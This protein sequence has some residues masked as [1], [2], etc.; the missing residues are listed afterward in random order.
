MKSFFAKN[1][2]WIVIITLILVGIIAFRTRPAR[3]ETENL[4]N[5]V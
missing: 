3:G 5:P 1:M 2:V 4:S